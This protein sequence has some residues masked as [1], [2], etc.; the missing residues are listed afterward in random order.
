MFSII[1]SS[2]SMLDRKFTG[3]IRDKKELFNENKTVSFFKS[4][5]FGEKIIDNSLSLVEESDIPFLTCP[6]E[7]NINNKG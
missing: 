1:F 7:N 4:T 2:N 3:F 6:L 5:C